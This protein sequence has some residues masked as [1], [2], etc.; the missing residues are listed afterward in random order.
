MTDLESINDINKF[1][2][3]RKNSVDPTTYYF[4]VEDDILT[5]SVVI[6]R[7]LVYNKVKHS[8]GIGVY[9]DTDD[10]NRNFIKDP[11]FKIFNGRNPE[12][13]TKVTRISIF[14]PE[15][16][17]HLNQVWNLSAKEK[18]SLIKILE[19]MVGG[20]RVW[21]KILKLCITESKNSLKGDELKAFLQTPIP[22][23]TQLVD[24]KK[25]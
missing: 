16:V 20:D 13:S 9:P 18:R 8:F 4:Y 1:L 22:D 15:Y 11:Y 12:D 21:D 19:T 7:E 10:N 2:S 23:Y 3:D 17:V 6:K 5:E 24:V 14:R 25:K